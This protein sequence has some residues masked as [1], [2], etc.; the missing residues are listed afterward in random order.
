VSPND[1]SLTHEW[2]KSTYHLGISAAE[3]H[4]MEKNNMYKTLI[5]L[6]CLLVVII[7]IKPVS[8]ANLP[9]DNIDTSNVVVDADAQLIAE[10]D[11]SADDIDLDEDDLEDLDDSDEDD[12]DEDE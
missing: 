9:V 2:L 1:E 7:G 3:R 4:K 11:S 6:A 12:F 8:A 10:D 5:A